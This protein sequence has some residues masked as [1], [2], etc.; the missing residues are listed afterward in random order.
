MSKVKFNIENTAF[1]LPSVLQND[2]NKKQVNPEKQ[3]NEQVEKQQLTK[4]EENKMRLRK[5][6]QELQKIRTGQYMQQMKDIPGFNIGKLQ[7]KAQK[8]G[9]AAA[10]KSLTGDA[11]LGNKIE[12]AAYSGQLKTMQQTALLMK[13]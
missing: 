13:K 8:Q 4:T 2:P 12:Q 7:K 11:T 3:K 5:K 10:V 6:R 9:I 1:P